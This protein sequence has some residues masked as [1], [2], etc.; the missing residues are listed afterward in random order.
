MQ[1]ITIEHVRTWHYKKM[2]HRGEL[3]N[4]SAALLLYPFWQGYIINMS[5]YDFRKG[6]M[7]PPLL[8]G[9]RC[10]DSAFDMPLS[11]S[12]NPMSPSY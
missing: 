7:P 9:A 6:H 8:A 1:H 11:T 10:P 5:G 4:G 3:S 2:R 12:S